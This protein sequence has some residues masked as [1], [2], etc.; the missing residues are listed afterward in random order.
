MKNLDVSEAKAKK[1]DEME[2]KALDILNSF[3]QGNWDF[4]DKVKLAMQGLS[5]VAKNRQTLTAR[6]GL[7]F[8]MVS[9][10]TDDPK[11]LKKYIRATSPEIG[12]LLPGN[13]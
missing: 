5:V 8:N 2:N 1:L 10:I 3:F 9:T 6:E 7:R 4:S 13:K 12:K 11:A